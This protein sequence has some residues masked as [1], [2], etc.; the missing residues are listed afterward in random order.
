M[1]MV[2]KGGLR[3]DR[4]LPSGKVKLGKVQPYQI[5]SMF[6]VIT[7]ADE[8]CWVIWNMH[9][10]KLVVSFNLTAMLALS[11]KFWGLGD[12]K[13]ARGSIQKSAGNC[14][15]GNQLYPLFGKIPLLWQIGMD[16][17]PS[18]GHHL[19]DAKVKWKAGWL[20]RTPKEGFSWQE[21]DAYWA[22]PC[23]LCLSLVPVFNLFL[24]QV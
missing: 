7:F 5:S 9:F 12:W 13:R 17:Y 1:C 11:D 20:G 21:A 22:R 18:K 2:C 6:Q 24:L 8:T 23:G 15:V 19:D 14:L 16:R 3:L 4:F 10:V